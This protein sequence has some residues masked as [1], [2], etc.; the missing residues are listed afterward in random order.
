MGAQLLS[1]QQIAGRISGYSSASRRR[2]AQTPSP[3]LFLVVKL[4]SSSGSGA[5]LGVERQQG[6]FLCFP[7]LWGPVYVRAGAG[8]RSWSPGGLATAVSS[9]RGCRH[10]SSSSRRWESSVE[11]GGRC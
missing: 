7:L 6:S 1:A 10:A 9:R 5:S 8:L 3:F 4:S 2:A 11:A